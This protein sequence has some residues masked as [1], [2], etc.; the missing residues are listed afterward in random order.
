VE[1]L[2]VRD[3]DIPAVP[4]PPPGCRV[5]LTN[6]GIGVVPSRKVIGPVGAAPVRTVVEIVVSMATRLPTS[7][8]IGEVGGVACVVAGLTRRE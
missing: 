3:A 5:T 6:P 7:V 4:P 8:N 2:A 1:K